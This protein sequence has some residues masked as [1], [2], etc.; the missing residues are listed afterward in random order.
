MVDEGSCVGGGGD[1]KAE[2]LAECALPPPRLRLRAH[3]RPPRCLYSG[4]GEGVVTGEGNGLGE[5]DGLGDGDE[6]FDGEGLN[7]VDLLGDGEGLI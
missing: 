5:G 4:L 7:N 6:L 2:D 3:L 1:G